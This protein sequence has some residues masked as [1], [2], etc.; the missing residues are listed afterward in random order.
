MAKHGVVALTK[1]FKFSEPKV[2]D[3]EGIKCY[4]L[5]PWYVDTNLVRSSVQ[6]SAENPGKWTFKGQNIASMEDLQKF[7]KLRV[8]TVQEVGNA[9]IKSLEY[10]KVNTL[11]KQ[12]SGFLISKDHLE[13]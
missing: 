2:Y 13:I 12:A 6:L 5:A 3:V 7:K 10:D 1:S 9:L 8:L 4:A 11:R